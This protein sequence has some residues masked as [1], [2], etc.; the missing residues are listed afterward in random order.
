MW[1]IA[2]PSPEVAELYHSDPRMAHAIIDVG[3]QLT[4]ILTA[5]LIGLLIGLLAG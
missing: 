4:R 2:T 1:Q 3:P 5:L